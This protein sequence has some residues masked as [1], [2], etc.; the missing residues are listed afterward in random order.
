MPRRI[1]FYLSL[2]FSNTT[3]GTVSTIFAV[4]PYL[5]GVFLGGLV[6]QR[7]GVYRALVTTSLLNSVFIAGTL[8]LVYAGDSEPFLVGVVTGQSIA[9]GTANAVFVAYIASLTDPRYTATQFAVFTALATLA[10]S[11]LTAPTGW[12]AEQTGWAVYFGLCTVLGL[13]GL[14]LLLAFKKLFEGRRSLAG[15]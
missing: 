13:T 12:I 15:P 8:L 10:R 5:A 6:H 4:G 14:L 11:V 1:P 2:G 7:F 9:A 3:I